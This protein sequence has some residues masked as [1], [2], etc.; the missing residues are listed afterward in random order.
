LISQINTP[1]GQSI[2]FSNTPT[3]GDSSCVNFEN[4][5]GF[6]SNSIGVNDS[7]YTAHQ[8]IEQNYIDVC[9]FSGNDINRDFVNE[10]VNFNLYFLTFT[11]RTKKNQV[12]SKVCNF[13]MHTQYVTTSVQNKPL[14]G[15]VFNPRFYAR[16]NYFK[17]K[18]ININKEDI[19][20][21]YVKNIQ[22]GKNV[23]M[24][25]SE[26]KTPNNYY[27][28]FDTTHKRLFLGLKTANCIQYIYDKSLI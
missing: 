13:I 24:N 14:G 27:S 19:I 3:N 9:T 20:K 11:Y 26:L 17:T 23:Y 8:G 4:N 10:Y 25:N 22:T 7:I 18:F 12:K 2:N 6:I 15:K 1:A 5:V 28:L 21:I 16:P